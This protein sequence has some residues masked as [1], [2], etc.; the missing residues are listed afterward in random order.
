[1]TNLAGYVGGRPYFGADLNGDG[2]LLDEVTMA[3]PSQTQTRRYGVIANLRWDMSENHTVRFAYTYDRA[4]HR[5]TGEVIGLDIEGEPLDVFAINAGRADVTGAMLQKR[6][7]LSLAILHQVSGEYRGE[8]LDN[9]LTV[10]AGLR[11]PF[12]TRD[13]T[14]NCFTTSDSGFVD[15][16]TAGNARN[17]TYAGLNPTVQGPQ[18]R[19][20]KYDAILPN[21]GFVFK[22]DSPLSVFG[23]YSKGLQVPGTDALYNAF[24]FVPNTPSARPEPETSNNFDLGL[25][26]TNGRIQA[27]LVGWYTQYDNRLASA[28]DPDTERNVYRNL[29]RVNKYG[30]DGSIAF[31]PVDQF[32]VYVFGSWMKS[33]IKDNI[34]FGECTAAQVSVVAGCTAVGAPLFAATAGRREAGAPEYSYGI[35]GRGFFGPVELGLTAKRTGGRNLY[36]TNLPIYGGTQAAPYQLYPAETNPYWLVNLDLRLGLEFLGLDDKTYFQFNV[37]NLFDTLYVGNY[38]TSLNQGNVIAANTFL[39]TPNTPPFAQ[40]GAPR[41]ISGTFTIRF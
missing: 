25:R 28:Y 24:F 16:F 39:G 19:V 38:T 15:C 21:L 37:Y 30:I 41:T 34:Q 13:L 7:R 40:I 17:A 22:T 14:N 20:L 12:F 35:Q 27:Q 11:A 8:F 10:T 5:Q 1:V 29:G 23:N 33:E 4:R 3:A 26:Y 31:K 18:Q 6:D 9:R 32:A 2:D 36:D